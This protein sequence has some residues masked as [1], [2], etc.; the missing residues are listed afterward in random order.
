MKKTILSLTLLLCVA[1]VTMT[2]CGDDEP[3]PAEQT[4]KGDNSGQSD[5]TGN[6]K[7]NVVNNADGYVDLGLPSGTLWA[8]CNVGASEPEEYGLYFA[9]GETTS[10]TGDISDGRSFDWVSYKHCNDSDSAL[11]KYCNKSQ[12]GYDGFTD[13]KT[14]LDLSDDAAYVN[15]G[16]DWRM[17]SLTQFNELINSSY[18]TTKWVS[19][20]GVYGRLITSKANGNCIFLPAAG[21]RY[22]TALDG[23]GSYGYYWSRT[24]DVGYPGGAR[25]LY[26]LADYVST[27]YGSY[28]CY[29][30][31][32]RPVRVSQ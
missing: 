25:S 5:N 20:N 19:V 22:G 14:E 17:P 29:G 24:L 7:P 3:V 26:F 21:Y 13:S 28:R 4:G 32:V 15:C 31:S 9:W 30:P 23:A 8:T 12:Y 2:S 18:T 1:C 16:A 27:Y 10:Y 6:D 11:T